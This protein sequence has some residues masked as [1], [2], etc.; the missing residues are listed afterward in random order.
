MAY[1]LTKTICFFIISVA[2]T[3]HANASNFLM[4]LKESKQNHHT[5]AI[6]YFTREISDINAEN[7]QYQSK[8]RI[9]LGFSHLAAQHEFATIEPLFMEALCA[10][11]PQQYAIDLECG[12]TAHYATGISSEPELNRLVASL[13]LIATQEW[14]AEKYEQSLKRSTLVNR[15]LIEN[16]NLDAIDPADSNNSSSKEKPAGAESINHNDYSNINS[17]TDLLSELGRREQFAKQD[18]VNKTKSLLFQGEKVDGKSI[19]NNGRMVGIAAKKYLVEAYFQTRCLPGMSIDT[20]LSKGKITQTLG[21]DG[22]DFLYNFRRIANSESSRDDCNPNKTEQPALSRSA[23]SKARIDAKKIARSLTKQGNESAK[24]ASHQEKYFQRLAQKSMCPGDGLP[25]VSSVDAVMRIGYDPYSKFLEASRGNSLSTFKLAQLPVLDQLQLYFNSLKLYT[26][27]P[28]SSLGEDK[29]RKN[30][31]Q[32]GNRNGLQT[33][34]EISLAGAMKRGEHGESYYRRI[35]ETLLKLSEYENDGAVDVNVGLIETHSRLAEKLELSGQ[36][37]QAVMEYREAIKI[38]HDVQLDSENIGM[39][40]WTRVLKNYA[41]VLKHHNRP[42]NEIY[43]AVDMLSQKQLAV[44]RNSQGIS[45]LNETRHHKEQLQSA[46]REKVNPRLGDIQAA[47][48]ATDL[49]DVYTEKLQQI[50][51]EIQNKMNS[52]EIQ[53]SLLELMSQAPSKQ[54]S[55]AKGSDDLSET[56]STAKKMMDD[57]PFSRDFSGTVVE[58]LRNS[59]NENRLLKL[60]IARVMLAMDDMDS[61]EKW[62]LSSSDIGPEHPMP[63]YF[64]SRTLSLEAHVKAQYFKRLGQVNRAKSYYALAIQHWYFSPHSP[65]EHLDNFNDTNTAL[66][67]EAAAYNLEHDAPD[68]AFDYL[69]LARHA[70]IDSYRLYGRLNQEGLRL[71]Q[72]RL[73]DQYQNLLA[74][75][76]QQAA[77]R[78]EAAKFALAEQDS[79]ARRKASTRGAITPLMPLYTSLVPCTPWIN[80]PAMHEFLSG[81]EKFNASWEFDTLFE[82]RQ[83]LLTEEYNKAVIEEQLALSTYAHDASGSDEAQQ[84]LFG[85]E[86]MFRSAQ[87]G[88]DIAAP[89]HSIRNRSNESYTPLMNYAALKKTLN[90]DET[91]LSYWV[92]PENTYSFAATR[93]KL[94]TH[95]FPTNA[96]KI[97]IKGI[98]SSNNFHAEDARTLHKLL[99]EPLAG[100]LRKNVIIVTNGPLQNISFASLIDSNDN[101]FFGAKHPTRCYPD[102]DTIRQDNLPDTPKNNR[103]LVLAPGNVAGGQAKLQN[104][105]SEAESISKYFNT[106]V[107]LDEDVTRPLVQEKLPQYSMVHFAGHARLDSSLPDFSRLILAENPNGESSFYVRDIRSM[108]LK[109][110]DLVVLSACETGSTTEFNLDNEFSALNSAFLR[111]GADSVVATLRLVKDEIAY[112]MM[113]QFYLEL[114]K[115]I[116]KDEALQRAQQFVQDQGV[117]PE[118]WSSFVLSGSNKPVSIARN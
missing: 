79:Q 9:W 67:E 95:I 59:I 80:Q 28:A 97:P 11:L 39:L 44:L 78:G 49:P 6:E 68:T 58:N 75:A 34:L 4:A 29:F 23:R 33:D 65:Q 108:D 43:E 104:Y 64:S 106:Q 31:S 27:S 101:S 54:N 70:Y 8:I 56:F 14:N 102:I 100:N 20:L 38:M 117:G 46:M 111:A 19:L 12:A 81:L 109:G 42:L 99:I 84:G 76:R 37:D 91:L 69:E 21:K 7:W 107:Y 47:T 71:F 24:L 53:K 26:T 10:S 113:A 118:D 94:T 72:S 41:T 22:E 103:I 40:P 88:K 93:E 96:L 25:D 92:T 82:L 112:K 51:T 36:I 30:V 87:S 60:G 98:T 114:A 17:M 45:T 85:N 55:T 18:M 3:S 16:T 57:S 110:V 35:L 5:Q 86:V 105:I 48:H 74:Q 52:E 32:C 89:H 2:I 115:G 61:T 15:I 66:L 83:D 62:L 13:A 77:S 90:S 1:R 73:E 50:T 116:R 63:A